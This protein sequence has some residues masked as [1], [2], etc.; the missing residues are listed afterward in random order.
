M[1]CKTLTAQEQIPPVDRN[2]IPLLSDINKQFKRLKARKSYAR[3]DFGPAL[4]ARELLLPRIHNS[5]YHGILPTIDL[6]RS[7]GRKCLVD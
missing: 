6:D 2:I 3:K 1:K 5:L 4:D 7:D